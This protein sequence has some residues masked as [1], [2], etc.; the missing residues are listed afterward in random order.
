MCV[1]TEQK[2]NFSASV[3]AYK[4]SEKGH[5]ELTRGRVCVRDTSHSEVLQKH[6][7]EENGEKLEGNSRKKFVVSFIPVKDGAEH[8]QTHSYKHS[9]CMCY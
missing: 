7:Q 1:Q 8:K 4:V 6:G 3:I 5:Y 2:G 9:Q